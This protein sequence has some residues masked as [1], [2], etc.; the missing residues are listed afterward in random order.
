[1]QSE[2]SDV[3]VSV[4]I[5]TYNHEKFISQA[6]D[7]VLSQKVNFNFEIIIGEDCS[8]DKTR[9]ICIL[10]QNKYPHI[11]KLILND[12]NVGL[13]KNNITTWST[14]SGKYIAL[15]EGDDYWTDSCKL[16]KQVDFL[17][18]NNDYSTCFHQTMI[19]HDQMDE[20]DRLFTTNISKNIFEFNDIVERWISHT[21]SLVFRN[22]FN[23]NPNH[24]IF[25]SPLFWS[26]RP[27][28]AFLAKQGKYY[29]MDEAMSCWRQYDGN[30][31]KSKK[32]HELNMEGAEAFRMMIQ[33]FPESK[34]ILSEQVVRWS[35]LASEFVY[36][37]RKWIL[38]MKYSY[39]SFTNINSWLGFKNYTKSL[40]FILINKKIYA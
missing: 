33:I 29:Y 19:K 38:F 28:E 14:C 13:R 8:T 37:K 32:L 9:D 15:C 30:M 40:F 24:P 31:S 16:Q 3:L 4:A 35:L 10:Y 6:I 18:S 34:K 17:E 27:L 39:Y 26:D 36:S 21:T 1:M 11:I 20:S 22:F 23:E 25:T 12:K 5:V 7:S 2:I